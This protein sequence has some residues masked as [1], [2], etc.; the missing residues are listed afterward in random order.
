L[1][2]CTKLPAAWVFAPRDAW[3]ALKPSPLA[4]RRPD[5]RRQRRAAEAEL[6]SLA[7]VSRDVSMAGS[8]AFHK[9]QRAVVVTLALALA[10][11]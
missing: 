10:P 7:A 4:R 6:H 2:G 1:A 3:P 9:N 5:D 8:K 11:L